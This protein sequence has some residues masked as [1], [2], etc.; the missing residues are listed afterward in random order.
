IKYVVVMA[1]FYEIKNQVV[2]TC[3]ALTTPMDIGSGAK[4]PFDLTASPGSVP[5]REIANYSIRVSHQ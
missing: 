1:T 2:G 5:I 3:S 4:A